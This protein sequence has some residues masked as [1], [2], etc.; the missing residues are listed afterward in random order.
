MYNINA[1]QVCES[2]VL[3]SPFTHSLRDNWWILPFMDGRRP[4]KSC[5]TNNN[6]TINTLFDRLI[7]QSIICM[8]SLRTSRWIALIRSW[9]SLLMVYL[10]GLTFQLD[11]I[12]Y[13]R[14]YAKCSAQSSRLIPNSQQPKIIHMCWLFGLVALPSCLTD[15]HGGAAG[16][17]IGSA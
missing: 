1:E 12:Y 9:L 5:V 13:D 4:A 17:R 8:D 15:R 16:T 14:P 10:F 2:K 6:V 3:G 11:Y 7:T